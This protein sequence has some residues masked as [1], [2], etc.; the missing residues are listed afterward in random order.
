MHTDKKH[1]FYSG[2]YKIGKNL[3]RSIEKRDNITIFFFFNKQ[4]LLLWIVLDCGE[5]FLRH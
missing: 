5:S 4:E 1:V 3:F 2:F